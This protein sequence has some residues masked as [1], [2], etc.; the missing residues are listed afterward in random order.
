MTFERL[1]ET[2]LAGLHWQI[3][4]IYLDDVIVIG[5]TF[6][7]MI[8]NLS[9]IFERLQQAGLKLKARKCK[10]FGKS[11][12]FLGHIITETGVET[13]PSKTRCIENWPTPKTAKEVRAFI[14][15]CSYYR[16]FVYRFA[17]IAKPLHKLTE[18]NQPF[19][20]TEECSM[21]FQALKKK[22]VEAPV[23]I[24]PDFTS[25]LSIGAVLSQDTEDGECVIAYASRTLSKSERRYCV[26][27][28][29]MLALVY[30]VKYFRH[31]LYG[32]QFT[33]R[34]D[35]GS[36]RWL[37]NFK[38]PE[39]QVAR[40]LKFLSSFDM[41]IEHRPGRSHRNADG[42]SRIPCRQC[43]QD[44]VEEPEES[45]LHLT[46]NQLEH[47]TTGEAN[48]NLKEAQ[49]QNKEWL[50]KGGKPK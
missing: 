11:V 43:G 28:K 50:E 14:G 20:W 29:E 44:D 19:V 22:L 23:L 34:T 27:R 15:L 46:V 35:H 5:K 2:V 1:M 10:L 26:T 16:R 31:Y 45:K 47:Q 12:E 39:G 3:C 4:L 41:K 49:S 37:M 13:D 18:K 9:V 24:H 33:I 40:W 42:V 48:Q 8:K 21:S 36:L 6:E 32:R 17:E 30:F 7:D 25:D 38:N